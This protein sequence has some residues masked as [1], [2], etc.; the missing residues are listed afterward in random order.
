[1]ST[2]ER[3]RAAA[4]LAAFLFAVGCGADETP[5][6][7]RGGSGGEGGSGGSGP[8]EPAAAVYPDIAALHGEGILRTCSLNV[9]VCH[10]ARNYPELGLASS[11]LGMVNAP[12]QIAPAAPSIVPD[13]CERPGDELVLGGAG[14]EILEVTIDPNEP[15]PPAKVTLRLAAAPASLDTTGAR[16]RR[17]DDAGSEVLSVALDAATLSPGAGPNLLEMNLAAAMP[18]SRDFLDVRVTTADRVRVGD[19]NGNGIAHASAAPWSLVTP[20][21]PARSFLY[22]R[23]LSDAFGPKMPLI[24]R[25]WSALATR[26]IYCW[27]RGMRPETS[28]ATLSIHDP[29]DYENC[30]VDPDAPAP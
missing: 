20:G 29:I 2:K 4:L 17:L 10:S 30:P 11:V 28:A 19:P 9:G 15:F 7:G 5:V 1:M 21:D 26:A 13:A 18:T 3:R 27:I 12:C 8:I 25:T 22:Q 6:V 16:V 23:L 24:E 14:H